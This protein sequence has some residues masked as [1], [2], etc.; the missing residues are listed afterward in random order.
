M[1]DVRAKPGK[2]GL[3]GR[4]VGCGLGNVSL[5]G[6]GIDRRLSLRYCCLHVD[7]NGAYVGSCGSTEPPA[8]SF[9]WQRERIVVKSKE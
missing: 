7:S 2:D 6:R 1:L 8:G 5:V 4:T 3:L 9:S